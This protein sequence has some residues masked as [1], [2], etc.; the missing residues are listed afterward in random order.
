MT[1]HIA[2]V[3]RQRVREAM[4][5]QG[6]SNAELARRTNSHAPNISRILAG[7]EQVS[8][9]RADRIAEALSI[10]LSSLVEKSEITS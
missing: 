6:V 2:E 5:E 8:L 4:D 1:T 3:F 7:L 10:P 9:E